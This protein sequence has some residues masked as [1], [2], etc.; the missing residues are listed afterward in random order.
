LL[1]DDASHRLAVV[2]EGFPDDFVAIRKFALWG[3][4]SS[5]NSY[6]TPSEEAK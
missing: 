1:R 5:K 6:K 4:H 3:M 2:T